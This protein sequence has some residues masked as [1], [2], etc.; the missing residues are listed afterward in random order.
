[1]RASCTGCSRLLCTNCHIGLLLCDLC[2]CESPHSPQTYLGRQSDDDRPTTVVAS[3]DQLPLMIPLLL[4]A[5]SLS[6]LPFPRINLRLH[7]ILILTLAFVFDMPKLRLRRPMVGLEVLAAL[8]LGL[9]LSGHV[10]TV[11]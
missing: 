10:S 6:P 7:R 8:I 4:T 11:V 2:V 1:M 3:P 9:V 5:Q